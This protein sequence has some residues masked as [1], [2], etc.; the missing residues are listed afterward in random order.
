MSSSHTSLATTCLAAG[1]FLSGCQ[2]GSTPETPAQPFF[3]RALKLEQRDRLGQPSW[4]LQSPEARYDLG[5]RVA[6]ARD[7]QGQLFNRGQL[8]YRLNATA[9][10]VLNDGEIVQLEGQIK[11]EAYGNNP[12]TI[13]AR[14]GRWFPNRNLLELDYRPIATQRNL[15]LTAN[16]LRFLI[17]QDKLELR[18]RPELQRSGENALKLEVRSAEWFT[19][20]GDLMALGPVV[21][22]RSL[23]NKKEQR[24]TS[25]SLTGNSIAQKLLLAAPVRLVDTEKGAVLNALETTV[26]VGQE[27][28]VSA[29]PFN[30]TMKQARISG[31]GFMLHSRTQTAIVT[32][33]CF[34]QQPTDSI[35][36]N[37]CFWN[38][39]TNQVSARGDVTLKRQANQQLTRAKRIDGRLGD[40]GLVVFTSP[41]GRVNTQLRL[42]AK[43]KSPAPSPARQ[44]RSPIEL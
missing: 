14:R 35:G 30:G 16:R 29:L 15:Q 37:R 2:F 32:S 6:Q 9:G 17:D 33:A 40:D 5:R 4:A 8:R 1:L 34:L 19:A 44:Q 11:L 10:T 21:G 42:P 27:L 25:P 22:V 12:F 20:K 38:W 26:D 18:G 3:F 43:S 23:A 13:R 28:I 7:L 24:L 41:G 31:G 39:Q 36:A